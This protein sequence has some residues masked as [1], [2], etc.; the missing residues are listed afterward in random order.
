MANINTGI[1]K[2]ICTREG[3]LVNNVVINKS[4]LAV[5]LEHLTDIDW[6]E[7]TIFSLLNPDLSTAI[8]AV[9]HDDSKGDLKGDSHADSR[10]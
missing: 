5:W 9:K 1:C 6:S 4:L 8:V 10:Q 2:S 3:L 7:N